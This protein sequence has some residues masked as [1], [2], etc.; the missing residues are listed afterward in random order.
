MTPEQRAKVVPRVVFIGGK[1][2]PGYDV[3]KRIIRLIN[4][5]GAVV[6]ADPDTSDMFKLLFI[7]NYN[8]SAAEIIIPASDLSQH[9]STAG[10]EASGTRCGRRPS[11]TRCRAAATRLGHPRRWVA[12]SPLLACSNARPACSRLARWFDFRSNMKFAM[13]GGLIIGTMD[14]A[15][16]EIAAEIGEENMCVLAQHPVVPPGVAMTADAWVHARANGVGPVCAGSSSA[17]SLSRSPSSAWSFGETPLPAPPPPSLPLPRHTCPTPVALTSLS[18]VLC[19]RVLPAMAAAANPAR[20]WPRCWRR[21]APASSA[22]RSWWAPSCA[23]W[24]R[25]TTTTW[26]PP[27]SPRV[28]RAP[29]RQPR[30]GASLGGVLLTLPPPP[31]ACRRS[32]CADCEAQIAVDECYKNQ[33]E[34]TRRS[35]LSTAGMGKFST[36]RT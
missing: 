8:V 10:M 5:V 12:C 14:G 29:P 28:R 17:H 35:I 11:H 32:R 18:S 7:P 21:C 33:A 15:N 25:R 34:W 1:A 31:P 9:I 22:A 23:T 36:D 2:A 3:A 19:T 30:T 4:A 13:N 26:S 27:T 16:I 24:R 6:N 20:C